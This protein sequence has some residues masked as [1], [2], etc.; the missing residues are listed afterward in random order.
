MLGGSKLPRQTETDGSGPGRKPAA[1]RPAESERR[2]GTERVKEPETGEGVERETQGITEKYSG[3]G[4]LRGK[5]KRVMG[6]LGQGLNQKPKPR[7]FTAQEHPLCLLKQ[8]TSAKPQPHPCASLALRPPNTLG[9]WSTHRAP[10]H[11]WGGGQVVGGHGWWD[12]K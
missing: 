12:L 8:Q 4:K 3:R 6:A 10:C 5:T 2:K 11:G 7:P 9:P 1:P